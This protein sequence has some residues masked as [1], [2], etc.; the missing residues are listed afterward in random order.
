MFVGWCAL[1]CALLLA[2]VKSSAQV[3][4]TSTT[5][6]ATTS[7][8]SSTTTTAAPGATASACFDAG[9]LGDEVPSA[10]GSCVT[11]WTSGRQTNHLLADN[12]ARDTSIGRPLVVAASFV[13]FLLAARL[14]GG[15]RTGAR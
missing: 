3:D 1:A 15:F 5:T 6:S 4:P 11:A 7:T 12:A 9:K 2:P 14:V 8:T 13:V 10:D